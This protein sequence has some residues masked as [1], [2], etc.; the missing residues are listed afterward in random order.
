MKKL[1]FFSLAVMALAF[2][3]CQQEKPDY[4][5]G[6]R[7]DGPSYKPKDCVFQVR[8]LANPAAGED[9][10]DKYASFKFTEYT[11]LASKPVNVFY[12]I[13]ENGD[14]TTMPILFSFTGA[15]REG[16]TQLNAWKIFAD[17]YEFI[18]INPQFTKS[19][20]AESE[21][22]FCGVTSSK[23]STEIIDQQYWTGNIIESI[24]N[25]WLME[26]DGQQTG[27]RMF[28]HS[29]GA[30]FVGRML[31]T[32]P[33]ARVISAVAANPSSWPWPTELKSSN[34]TNYGWPYSMTALPMYSDPGYLEKVFGKKLYV[35]IG[36]NDTGTDSLDQSDAANVQGSLRYH[37]ALNFYQTC[38]E[39]A[40]QKGIKC[41]FELAE[42][43]GVGHSTYHMVYGYYKPTAANVKE[44]QL[45][46]NS[47]FLLLFK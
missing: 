23:T 38:T 9:D 22:Q 29:A 24:F 26:T 5:T 42:V 39:V 19:Y 25:Y 45:G 14:V 16:N 15:E 12:Y 43:D 20:W 1:V 37:R 18:V 40:Q 31:V 28:G 35:Q 33:D 44:E 8:G 4:G 36:K 47:A 6:I 17:T 34:G 46:P 10:A 13:P 2:A 3:G 41:N 21:Y 32:T 11:P 7:P 27:Y 30:Q